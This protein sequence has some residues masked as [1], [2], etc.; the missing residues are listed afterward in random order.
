[1]NK[2]LALA[3]A[4]LLSSFSFSQDK[5]EYIDNDEIISFVS[6]SVEAG[7]NIKALEYL[8]KINKNDSSYCSV[9]TSKSY[10][11]L[12]LERYDEAI[13]TINEGLENDCDTE[14]VSF[15]I[16]LAVAYRA[17]EDYL[18]AIDVLDSALVDYPNHYK[19][20]YNKALSLEKLGKLNEAISALQKTIILNPYYVYPHLR[21]GNICFKQEKMAQAIMCYNMYLLLQTDGADAP[22]IIKSLDN[23]VSATN[24]NKANPDIRI[25][26]DDDVFEELDLILDQKLALRDGYKTENEIDMALVR[27]NHVLLSQL[28]ELEGNG[29]FWSEKYIP[30]FNWITENNFFNDFAYTLLYSSDNEEHKKII[31][32]KSD[33][34]SAFYSAYR[35]KWKEIIASNIENVDGTDKVIMYYFNNTYVSA[36]GEVKDENPVGN[37]TY[38]DERGQLKATGTLDLNGERTGEW[39]WYYTDGTIKEKAVYDNGKLNGSNTQWHENGKIYIEA[40]YVSDSLENEYKSYNNKGALYQ[41]KYYKKGKLD[42]V[43]NSYFP[44]GED[45]LEFDIPYKNALVEG[46]VLEYYSNGNIYSETNFSGGVKNGV[47]K[48][49][50]VNKKLSSEAYFLN[51]NYHGNYKTYHSNG[52][53]Y[54]EGNYV[55]GA[56]EGTIKMY[57]RNGTLAGEFEYS[58]GKLDGDY[59]NYDYDGK[60]LYEYS[61]RNGKIIS[62]KFFDKKGNIIKEDRKKGGELFYYGFSSNGNITSEGLYDISGGK[63]GLWKFYTNNGVKYEEGN[64]IDDKAEGEHVTFFQDGKK[65]SISTYKDNLLNGYYANYYKNGQLK[66]Q[67]YYKDNMAHGE[68]RHYYINGTLRALE[69]YHKGNYHGDQIAYEANGKLSRKYAYKFGEMFEDARYDLN[70]E[71]FEIVTFEPKTNTYKIS[72][73]HFNGNPDVE[74]EYVNG[75]KHG[76]YLRYDYEGNKRLTGNYLN[77]FEHGAWVGYF[78]N[79]QIKSKYNYVLGEL[80]GE[81]IDYYENGQIEDLSHYDIGKPVG[82]RLSYYE[83]GQLKTV[84]EYNY[85][86]RHGR[87]EFYDPQGKLQLIRFYDHDVLIGY[88]YLDKNAEEI[89]MIKLENETGVITAYFDNG[90]LS[91]VME[92]MNGDLINSYKSYYYS[93]Q[94]EN[95]M[96]YKSG[97]YDGENIKYFSNGKV[98]TQI[99]YLYGNRN[100]VSKEFRED[101]TIKKEENYL[102]D[103]IIDSKEYNEKGILIKTKS[104]FD[105][106]TYSVKNH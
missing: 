63:K 97:E 82:K 79:G 33:D 12:E 68:W 38:Y 84:T 70:G 10:Y 59:K 3:T 49:Y 50:D 87:K 43:Y 103:K 31:D 75:I 92:Y 89:P 55:E 29:G 95:E 94:L 57:F 13:S 66:S 16:N 83:N 17:K 76:K 53:I 101:G 105:E 32:K 85:G 30:F 98:K 23:I 8:N 102:N 69:F 61:Y 1:M 54:E 21:L 67:G 46:Q 28:K 93:G 88:S 34:I 52:T 4:L 39:V 71:L 73:N 48:K 14:R 56:L 91:R 5:L 36:I 22:R 72:Y 2:F 64:Y 11:Q 9:L 62:Y 18:K 7:N 6:K 80:D 37:W 104:Y 58:N 99:S 90:K 78:K 74:I 100:G 42:G 44:V 51:G 26:P 45:I 47:Q 106:E 65:Q 27:Q 96:T 40:N 35:E 86:E 25:S 15:Y 20:W 41:K 24:S 60:P 81:A 19:L 77:G